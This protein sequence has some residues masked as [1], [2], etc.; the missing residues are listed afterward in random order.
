MAI[1][2]VNGNS[3]NA[4][5]D[6][7]N[8]Q[9]S[10][11]YDIDGNELISTPTS[12]FVVMTYNIQWF[13]GVNSN[14]A[15]QENIFDTYDADVIGFQEFQKA[16]ISTVPTMATQLLSQNYPYLSMGDYGN[17]NALASK[18]ELIDFTT[19]PHT[20]Q[21]MDGQSYSTAT[22]NFD[23]KEILLVV[24]HVTT[25]DYEATKVEQIG[26]VFDAIQNAEYFIIMSDFNTVC[27]SVND[28]EYS[29]I[30]KQFVDAGYNCANCTEQFGFL[31]TWTSSS[32][33]SGTWY[34]CDHVITSSN[35][36]I[37]NVIVDTT[38]IDIATQT[39][40]SIDHL[41]VIAYLTIN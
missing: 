37:D 23:G 8:A 25:S 7:D 24:S 9:L 17:K 5:Y 19:V 6:K 11:A 28:T 22:I 16:N 29:T 32:T 31:N 12:N 15:M 1:Y 35:I 34:P 20:T 41:P 38:K 30:M 10:Q 27:K 14:Q 4:I 33:A 3:L 26:E 39:G 2:D 36:T 18:Y 40:Q 21:T 13:T